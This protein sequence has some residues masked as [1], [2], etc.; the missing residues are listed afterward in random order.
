MNVRSPFT[1]VTQGPCLSQTYSENTKSMSSKS[2]LKNFG[3]NSPERR[4][5]Y[6]KSRNLFSKGAS[7]SLEQHM[8]DLV[9]K[10]KETEAA[11]SK[12]GDTI[13]LLT[14]FD[15]FREKDMEKL[16]KEV[17][18]FLLKS[19]KRVLIMS[20]TMLCQRNAV[21]QEFSE[22]LKPM[23][24]DYEKFLKT[25]QGSFSSVKNFF[26]AL[27]TVSIRDL[28]INEN[29]L[30]NQDL[31]FYGICVCQAYLSK[32][33]DLAPLG[34]EETHPST[35]YFE[36]EEY[37]KDFYANLKPGQEIRLNSFMNA[38]SSE[39]AAT[40]PVF[41]KIKIPRIEAY[42]ELYGG[43]VLP[44]GSA[45]KVAKVDINQKKIQTIIHL[46]LID[47]N[48]MPVT[49]VERKF[50]SEKNASFFIGQDYFEQIWQNEDL[51]QIP[52]ED[53]VVNEQCLYQR[54]SDSNSG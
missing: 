54:P 27:L 24:K 16:N 35:V 29:W 33:S 15:I 6:R 18:P 25:S 12:R 20:G 13:E 48:K 44:K 23:N 40:L 53:R 30:E 39:P 45:F 1:E 46:E 41:L 49:V 31:A 10:F 21:L 17:L 37:Q 11:K 34:P 4:Y 2:S 22:V 50:S 38:V 43:I 8:N 14:M 52:L 7:L 5:F 32:I 19:I 47:Q 42:P 26:D 51:D 3:R 9:D 28:P 36:T